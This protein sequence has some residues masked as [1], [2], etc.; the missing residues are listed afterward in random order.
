MK[1]ILIYLTLNDIFFFFLKKKDIYKKYYFNEENTAFSKLFNNL[2][3]IYT[4]M[5]QYDRAMELIDRS[6]SKMN[7]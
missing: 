4:E 6:M 5:G 7:T 2:A 3:K 1:N